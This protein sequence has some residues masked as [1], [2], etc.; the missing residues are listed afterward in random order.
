MTW[1]TKDSCSRYSIRRISLK[2]HK[3]KT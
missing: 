3:M 2:M 1:V